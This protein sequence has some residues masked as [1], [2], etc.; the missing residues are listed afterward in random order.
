MGMRKINPAHRGD[1]GG[2][3]QVAQLTRLYADHTPPI[4]RMLPRLNGVKSAGPHKYAA[5]CPAHAD[6]RP[7]LSI[8]ECED[9][10]LLLKCWAGCGA[11]DIVSAIGL[12]LR[13]LF[14]PNPDYR[15]PIPRGSRWVPR[16]A[17]EAL[18][19]ESMF[20][21]ICAEDIAKGFTL[22]GPE[23]ERLST[24]SRRFMSAFQEVAR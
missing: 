16:D 12:E 9:G 1:G 11:A 22:T 15:A 21:A 19:V 6:K 4:A 24:A 20:L 18:A 14:P 13:D 7:S 10:T 3:G 17:L 23:R 5:L 2:A 8:R